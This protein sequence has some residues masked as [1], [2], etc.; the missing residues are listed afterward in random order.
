MYE[1]I[2]TGRKNIGDL[3]EGGERDAQAD[4]TSLYRVD[5]EDKPNLMG[6]FHRLTLTPSK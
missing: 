2:V 4:G 3:G 6:M 1:Y 5:T